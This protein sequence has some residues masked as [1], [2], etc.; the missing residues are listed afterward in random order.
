MP[1]KSVISMLTEMNIPLDEPTLKVIKLIERQKSVPENKLAKFLSAKINATRKLLYRLNGQGIVAYVKKQ[2]PKKKWWYVYNWSLDLPRIH[3]HY[4][5]FKVKL[6]EQKRKQIEE[7]KQFVFECVPCEKRFLYEDA[8]DINYICP[9]CGGLLTEIKDGKI[10]RKLQA[11]INELQ[12]EIDALKP[13]LAPPAP[14]AKPRIKKP[15][16]KKKIAGQ[17]KP[18]PKPKAKQKPKIIAKKKKSF[19]KKIFKKKK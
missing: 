5:N 6:L 2:D 10:I 4:I 9:V 17:P 13:K 12:K 1:K 15:L 18:K 16:P 8:L 19:L 3:E 7:E 11:E 14:P